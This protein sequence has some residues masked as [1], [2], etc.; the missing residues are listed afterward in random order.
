MTAFSRPGVS[1]AD[2]QDVAA[3]Q[4]LRERGGPGNTPEDGIQ[5][6]LVG[7]TGRN[8][9]PAKNRSCLFHRIYRPGKRH[10]RPH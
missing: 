7:R 3:V 8:P 10:H 6:H 1:S 4:V 2:D 5:V 9:E